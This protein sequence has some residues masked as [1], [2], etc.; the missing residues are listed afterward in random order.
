MTGAP[1]MADL[2]NLPRYIRRPT[3]VSAADRVLIDRYE[4]ETG[5]NYVP[6]GV[7]GEDDEQTASRRSWTGHRFGQSSEFRHKQAQRRQLYRRLVD[8]GKTGREIAAVTGLK[9]ESVYNALARLRLKIRP[10]FEGP[11]NG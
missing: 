9:L 10:P 3:P 4:A 8:D 5:I 7:S 1:S 11:R 6:R 2:L